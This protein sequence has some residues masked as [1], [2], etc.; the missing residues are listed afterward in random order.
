MSEKA[1]K[2]LMTEACWARF[3]YQFLFHDHTVFNTKNKTKMIKKNITTKKERSLYYNIRYC[4]YS[5]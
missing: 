2:N 4:L 1:N 3:I 5:K